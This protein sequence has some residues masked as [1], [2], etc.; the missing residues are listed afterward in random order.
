[1]APKAA[2]GRAVSRCVYVKLMNK[3]QAHRNLNIA[4]RRRVKMY[5]RTLR[6]LRYTMGLQSNRIHSALNQQWTSL[7]VKAPPPAPRPPP[8][9]V[10]HGPV[11]ADPPAVAGG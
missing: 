11:A 6:R 2:R 7:H 4:L 5:E 1:M 9:A 3:F 10:M 8:A